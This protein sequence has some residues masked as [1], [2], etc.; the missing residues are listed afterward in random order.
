M[1]GEGF[2]KIHS[3]EIA[4]REFPRGR[5][6]RGLDREAVRSWLRTV[7]TAYEALEEECDRLRG[8]RDRT[9][10][11]LHAVRERRHSP[12]VRSALLS[13][14]IRRRLFGYARKD[15][16]PLLSS[17]IDELARLETRAAL[18]EAQAADVPANPQQVADRIEWLELEVADVRDLLRRSSE[19][20][21]S[22]PPDD[23]GP[24]GR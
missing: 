11:T 18:L 23:Q 15:V 14:R 24:D 3:A 6:K 1:P 9:R 2:P 13:A 19:P 5:G 12:S 4:S 20:T 22:A 21:T 10:T 16:D 8:E 17:L 7:A